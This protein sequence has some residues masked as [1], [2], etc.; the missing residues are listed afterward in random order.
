MA[1]HISSFGPHRP[2]R[3]RCGVHQHT[4][5]GGSS[6]RGFLMALCLHVFVYDHMH[7][8]VLTTYRN[9]LNRCRWPHC[10]QLTKTHRLVCL[11]TFGPIFWPSDDDS[12]YPL[13]SKAIHEK[14]YVYLSSLTWPKFL[15]SSASSRHE[16]H[17]RFFSTKLL[18]QLGA[19]RVCIQP[20]TR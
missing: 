18:A 16:Q 3:W 1:Q 5:P 15:I 4:C 6:L 14:L 17:A 13:L 20:L 11:L 10:A 8:F 7:F 12:S 2:L 9:E 19:E